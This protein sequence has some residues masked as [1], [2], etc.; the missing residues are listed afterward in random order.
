M[1]TYDKVQ[2]IKNGD[3]QVI[4]GE[5]CY[6]VRSFLSSNNYKNLAT[7]VLEDRVEIVAFPDLPKPESQSRF[8]LK[9]ESDIDLLP[10]MDIPFMTSNIP[11]NLKDAINNNDLPF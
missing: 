6:G 2:C 1:E 7:I 11:D 8:T 10:N 9:R 5:P 4:A 3:I